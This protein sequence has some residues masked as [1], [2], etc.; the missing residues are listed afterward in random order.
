MTLSLYTHEFAA[1]LP[2]IY[3]QETNFKKKLVNPIPKKFLGG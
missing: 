1:I 2:L 3:L